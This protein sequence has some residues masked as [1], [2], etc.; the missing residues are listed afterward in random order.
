MANIR[1]NIRQH[2]AQIRLDLHWSIEL[3]LEVSAAF[4][5]KVSTEKETKIRFITQ[6]LIH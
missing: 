6:K 2:N 5:G 1:T 4:P 3:K